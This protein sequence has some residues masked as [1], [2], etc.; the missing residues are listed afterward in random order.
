[1][2][3]FHAFTMPKQ[4]CSL[5]CHC[6]AM[7]NT[8]Q[9]LKCFSCKTCSLLSHSRETWR[10][11][12][13][14]RVGSLRWENHAS[15]HGKATSSTSQPTSILL[16]GFLKVC[17]KYI[18]QGSVHLIDGAETIGLW[19]IPQAKVQKPEFRVLTRL[20]CKV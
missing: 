7:H 10:R 18:A 2:V 8:Q 14:Y 9:Q 20:H 4:S 16:E 13:G 11:H 12:G 5:T 1:M 6:K 19:L 17:A 3:S 15:V